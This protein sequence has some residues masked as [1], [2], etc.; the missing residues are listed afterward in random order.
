MNKKRIVMLLLVTVLLLALTT[1]VFALP[2][3]PYCGYGCD[4]VTT[5]LENG[6]DQVQILCPH[7]GY[8]WSTTTVLCTHGVLFPRD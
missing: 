6:Y 8:V 5:C 1:T 7:C 3:C 4:R 2:L